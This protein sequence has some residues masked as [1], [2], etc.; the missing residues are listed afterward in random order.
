AR[1]DWKNPFTGQTGTG[2]ALPLTGDTG[3]FWFFDAANLELM[4]KVL[5][6]GGV[7][8]HSWVFYGSLSNVEYTITVTDTSTG[9]AKTYHNAPFQFASQADVEAFP[10]A[11]ASALASAVPLAGSADPAAAIPKLSP[12]VP[13]V[14]TSQRFCLGQGRFEVKV[15]FVD[16]RTGATGQAQGVPLTDD[17][18]TFWFFAPANLEL[19]VKVLDAQGVNGHF[20]VFYGALSDVEYTI[21]VTDFNTGATRTY[22]NAAH[23]LA[24]G[25]DLTA[26]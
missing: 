21:T 19:T 10:S 26:F 11:P 15:S 6:G 3:A 8:G 13:C 4:I 23:H 1:V 14:G 17:T 5:D 25:A 7:N 9:T 22:R 16:P 18:G 24:S 2:K 20:W 12:A